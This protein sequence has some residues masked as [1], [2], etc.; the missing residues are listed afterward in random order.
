MLEYSLLNLHE[1]KMESHLEVT[2]PSVFL[3]SLTT[4][5][6][7]EKNFKREGGLPG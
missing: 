7:K 6:H 4:F 1:S 2:F 5:A 3:C